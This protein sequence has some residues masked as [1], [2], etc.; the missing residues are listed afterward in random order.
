MP[1]FRDGFCRFH[2][3]TQR[4]WKFYAQ[5]WKPEAAHGSTV[6]GLKNS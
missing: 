1:V 4:D 5:R 3:Q 6:R 2:L